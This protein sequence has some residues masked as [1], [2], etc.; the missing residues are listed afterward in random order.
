MDALA[1]S[2]A[3]RGT[4]IGVA[5]L[6]TALTEEQATTLAHVAARTGASPIVATD[7]DLAGQFAAQRDYWLLTQHALTPM[8]ATLRPANDPADV[9]DSAGRDALLL[10]LRGST[11]L[12]NTLIA[13]QLGNLGRIDAIREATLVLAASTADDWSHG[14]TAI[15]RATGTS[16]AAVRRELAR[17][18]QR[19]ADNPRKVVAERL[20]VFTAIREHATIA[21]RGLAARRVTTSDLDP[22]SP[23]TARTGAP[24][25]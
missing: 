4:Y 14:S 16:L 18:S 22:P 15:A 13:E 9:V 24:R 10:V 8:V 17:A 7:A 11:R 12:A 23:I 21:S 6:G 25:R 20:G 19:W 5:P 2:L 1:V 3:G